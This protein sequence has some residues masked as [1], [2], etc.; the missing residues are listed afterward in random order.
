[1]NYYVSMIYSLHYYYI[2]L[3]ELANLTV[4]AFVVRVGFL[5]STMSNMGCYTPVCFQEVRILLRVHG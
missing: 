4:Y 1:M 2:G 5:A 3:H